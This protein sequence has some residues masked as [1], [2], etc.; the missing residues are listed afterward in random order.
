MWDGML[1]SMD[2]MNA[3]MMSLKGITPEAMAAQRQKQEEDE[4]LIAQEFSRVKVLD[5][6]QRAPVCSPRQAGFCIAN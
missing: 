3:F 6:K 2:R 1:N 5:W 4:Q